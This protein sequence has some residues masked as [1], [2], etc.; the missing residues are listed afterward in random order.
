ME[1]EAGLSFESGS[2][3]AGGQSPSSR[4]IMM[5][6]LRKA[7]TAVSFD[8]DLNLAHA[9]M[10]YLEACELLQRAIGTSRDDSD[11][12]KLREIHNVFAT[13]IL[14]LETMTDGP[15]AF[16][17]VFTPTTSNRERVLPCSP[18]ASPHTIVNSESEPGSFFEPAS[19]SLTANESDDEDDEKLDKLIG[20]NL[21]PNYARR[22]F[23]HV[24]STDVLADFD[25]EVELA[26]AGFAYPKL[27]VIETIQPIVSKENYHLR[28]TSWAYPVEVASG[29]KQ[30]RV[31]ASMGDIK[32][33]QAKQRSKMP[34]IP[35]SNSMFAVFQ[36][37]R[38]APAPSSASVSASS[39]SDSVS[40]TF[41]LMRDIYA[42]IMRP[43]G[44]IIA[45]KLHLP[46]EALLMHS[47]RLSGIAD[48]IAFFEKVVGAVVR[49]EQ[50]PTF[51]ALLEFGDAISQMKMPVSRVGQQKTPGKR[52]RRIKADTIRFSG[53]F[54]TKTSFS[55]QS[56][57]KNQLKW[58]HDG[59]LIPSVI[60]EGPNGPYFQVVS[61]LFSRCQIVE[62]L[63]TQIKDLDTDSMTRVDVV[64]CHASEFFRRRVC[65]SV[66]VDIAILL[67]DYDKSK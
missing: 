50:S 32:R 47:T 19:P 16:T 8:N 24:Q 27:A 14:E 42:A 12:T 22:N 52:S 34:N 58:N 61:T 67:E 10:S 25:V 63:S 46:R 39:P 31:I 54:E 13:R 20:V 41:W 28:R 21:S 37:T 5:N 17:E 9:K 40:H 3:W 55:G 64:I 23:F 29:T 53:W 43:A 56:G 18:G 48:K 36:E 60:A 2:D 62:K 51:Q 6:A 30:V 38:A 15:V 4:R 26:L 49:L 66:L 45:G 7:S 11:R 35:A 65:K 57:K 59:T 33:V 1:L 44:D